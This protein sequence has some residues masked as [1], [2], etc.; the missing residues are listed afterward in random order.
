[1]YANRSVGGVN[2]A[3]VEQMAKFKGGYGRVVWMPTFDAENAVRFAKENRRRIYWEF[4]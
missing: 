1:M 2:A 3:A 4:W